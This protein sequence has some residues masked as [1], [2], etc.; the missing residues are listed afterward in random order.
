MKRERKR[1]YLFFAGHSHSTSP[2]KQVPQHKQNY[3]KTQHKLSYDQK[4][5]MKYREFIHRATP[6]AKRNETN[7]KS[8]RDSMRK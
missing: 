6:T 4:E 2:T 3:K 1:F 7:R 5:K 8:I